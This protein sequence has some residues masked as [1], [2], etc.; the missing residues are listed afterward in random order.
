[1]V[2]RHLICLTRWPRWWAKT[3]FFSPGRFSGRVLG[4]DLD[5]VITGP[6]DPLVEHEGIIYLDRWGWKNR[7]YG[8]SCMVWESG[9]HA[10]AF[11]EYDEMVPKRFDGDQDWLTYL[12]GWKELPEQMTRSYRYHCMDGPPPG[13]V[14]VSFHGSAKLPGKSKPHQIDSGWVREMWG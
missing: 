14:H 3:L 11:S 12:G 2:A 10:E 13:C 7:V 6:L 9:D 4:L 5:T 8:S 1:M